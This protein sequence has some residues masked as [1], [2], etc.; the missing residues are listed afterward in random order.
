MERG[1]GMPLEQ[2]VAK[3]AWL[4]ELRDEL[5]AMS[6]GVLEELI[7]YAAVQGALESS[8]MGRQVVPRRQWRSL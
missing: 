7:G 3:K 6:A 4:V 5:N 8:R 2:Q 1:L